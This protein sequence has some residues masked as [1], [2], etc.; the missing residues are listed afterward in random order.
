METRSNKMFFKSKFIE[1]NFF[2]KYKL[3]EDKLNLI[4]F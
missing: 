4:K 1:L 3:N 2:Q